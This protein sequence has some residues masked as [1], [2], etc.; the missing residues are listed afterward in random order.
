MDAYAEATLRALKAKIRWEWTSSQDALSVLD[1]AL[2]S[3]V[4]GMVTQ[5]FR[6]QGMVVA[7]GVDAI[8]QRSVYAD[9]GGLSDL[10]GFYFDWMQ[11][12]EI[13]Y[14]WRALKRFV[15]VFK[16]EWATPLDELA[17]EGS[18]DCEPLAIAI[19]HTFPLP[20]ARGIQHDLRVQVKGIL[21]NGRYGGGCKMFVSELLHHTPAVS[22]DASAVISGCYQAR[23]DGSWADFAEAAGFED[24]MTELQTAVNDVL[25]AARNMVVEFTPRR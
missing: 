11:L 6:A 22:L 19:E 24:V 5:L 17:C 16:I 13:V 4:L 2:R 9:I 12:A 10:K 18:L 23:V 8:H 25:D 15:D 1:Q 21:E 7:F 20:E 3:H 14:D